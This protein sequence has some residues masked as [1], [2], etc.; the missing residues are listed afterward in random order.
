M[1]PVQTF[2]STQ[3]L[4]SQ[5]EELLREKLARP[6]NL[7]LS[8]GSTPYTIYNRITQNPCPVHPERRLFLSDERMVPPDSPKN[9]AA[10]LLPMLRALKCEDQFIRVDTTRSPEEAAEK[11]AQELH[12][13]KEIDLAILGMGADGHTAG[14]FTLE[15]AGIKTGTLTLHGPRPDGMHGVTISPALLSR[16]KRILLLVPGEAKRDAIET[17]LHHPQTIPAGVA[18]SDLNQVTLWTDLQIKHD[19]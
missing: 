6:G 11:F 8:G 15:H 9:N 3:E 12:P 19:F 7:M 1:I 17:L 13:L 10:N 5:V 18:L 16:A 2:R 14:I 4:E